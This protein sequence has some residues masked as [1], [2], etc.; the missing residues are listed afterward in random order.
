MDSDSSPTFPDQPSVNV[1]L[2]DPVLKDTDTDQSD[3]DMEDDASQASDN[4]NPVIVESDTD[5]SDH[6]DSD[7][8]G[9]DID[10]DADA[11]SPD[12]A[13]PLSLELDE[14]DLDS[15][16]GLEDEEYLQKFDRAVRK[17]F[18]E[19]YHPQAQTHN[20]EE[21][22]ALAKVT[23]AA[24][25]RIVDALHRTTPVLTKYVPQ[26]MFTVIC[27]TINPA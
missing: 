9:S 11:A 1:P 17:R 12:S 3:S 4:P 2:E 26:I 21:V 27:A 15:D 5:G 14:S 19:E 13:A 10:P 18:I 7:T 20:Y 8:E 24:D 6:G 16:D 23:R 25:G 22:A